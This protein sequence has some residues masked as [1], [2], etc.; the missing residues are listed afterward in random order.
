MLGPVGLC[1]RINPKLKTLNPKSYIWVHVLD[2][3]KT[4]FTGLAIEA[5][6]FTV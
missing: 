6:R 2:V 5:L 3:Q 4:K 1:G